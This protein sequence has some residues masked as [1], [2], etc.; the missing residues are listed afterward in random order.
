M[1]GKPL[2]YVSS[3]IA[4]LG[5]ALFGYSQRINAALR[6][7]RRDD[8]VLPAI[9]I[10]CLGLTAFFA[11]LGS[12]YVSNYL[13]R[14]VSIRIGAVLYLM[15]SC[16]QMIAPNFTTLILDLG[17]L[18]PRTWRRYGQHHCPNLPGRDRA[19]QPRGMFAGLKAFCMK[20]GYAVLRLGRVRVLCPRTRV[21]LLA[22]TLRRRLSRPRRLDVP[23]LPSS[24]SGRSSSP[25]SPRW[26][27]QNGFKTEGLRTLADLPAADDVT[28]EGVNQTDYAIVDTPEID[29]GAVGRWRTLPKK[30]PRRTSIGFTSRI[31]S[32]TRASTCR[33]RCS[34][35][36]FARSCTVSARCP[37]SYPSTGQ[38]AFP[39]RRQ[40]RA[41]VLPRPNRVSAAVRRPVAAD[42]R[43][44][45]RRAG[46]VSWHG[47][48]PLFS[49][50][51]PG[52]RA[53]A[54][55]R[56][57]VSAAHARTRSMSITTASD[58]G[59]ECVIGLVTPPLLAA[60]RGAYYF[61][62]AGVWVLSGLAVWLGYVETGGQPLER[63]AGMFGGAPPRKLEQEDAV[64]VR[65]RR[66]GTRRSQ[67]CKYGG[68]VAS[69]PHG[70]NRRSS[71]HTV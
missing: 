39:R 10:A 44:P 27:I 53:M 64:Q 43:V 70:N 45:R 54:P 8:P 48:V 14:R 52:P 50:A 18:H 3:A 69:H 38:T 61:V 36:A 21:A 7:G 47:H 40:H 26:L 1:A 13:G 6:T 2:L 33:A 46:G 16:L 68:G 37:Q 19:R 25:E 28:D 65:R 17:V 57:A 60:L 59:F 49:S 42:A 22:G 58:W 41:R 66:V 56:R 11:A 24:S 71:S 63:I 30:Y 35:A 34:T 15:P 67:P 29:G 23:A 51:R 55:Q 12:A 9:L 5:D 62:L 31:T 32:R 4:S 20:A